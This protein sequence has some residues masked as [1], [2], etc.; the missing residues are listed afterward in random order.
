MRTD[1]YNHE[2]LM[3]RSREIKFW[4]AIFVLGFISMGQVYLLHRKSTQTILIP[5]SRDTQ[6]ILDSQTSPLYLETFGIYFGNLFMN[7][8]PS[9]IETHFSHILLHADPSAYKEI[10]EGL[11]KQMDFVKSKSV[12]QKTI[13]TKTKVSKS[14]VYLYGLTERSIGQNTLLSSEIRV[15]ID[16]QIDPSSH[17]LKIKGIKSC[18]L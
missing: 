2:V 12:S 6:Y 7:Y 16:F 1:I 13:I 14:T 15:E 8:A 10:K 9:D 17:M 11:S 18:D 4:I 3:L 5:P